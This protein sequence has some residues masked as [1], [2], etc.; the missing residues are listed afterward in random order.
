MN[1]RNGMLSS[2]FTLG[3]MAAAIFSL[4]RTFRSG[5]TSQPFMQTLTG[6]M[7]GQAAQ[8]MIQPLQGIMNNLASPQQPANQKKQ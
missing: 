1:N 4:V 2:L 7:N 5:T 8:S 3:A 6:S